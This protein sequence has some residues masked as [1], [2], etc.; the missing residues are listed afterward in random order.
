MS[1]ILKYISSL[2]L[3]FVAVY[4]VQAQK[5]KTETKTKIVADTIK[6]PLFNG[7]TVQGDLIS[8]VSSL[9]SKGETYSYEGA[10]QADF[11]HKYFPVL[12]FG[13]A[14]ADKLTSYNT[15]F[16]ANA[17]FGRLGLDFNMISQKKDKKPT[18]NL[19]LVGFRLGMSKFNYNITNVSITDDYW[20]GSQAVPYNN[21]S[22]TKVWYELVAGIR[23]EVIKD[24]FMGWTV[25]SKSLISKDADGNVTPWY[26]P[27]FGTNNGN[28]NTAINY[29]IGY[30]F[31]LPFKRKSAVKAKKPNTEI[32][33]DTKPD[34]K[35]RNNNQQIK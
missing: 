31:Q 3:C 26:I 35:P 25:R 19:F 14:G 21:I 7:F 33:P 22:T 15:G 16:K 29:T 5:T 34:T 23:V 8:A 28:A 20:G 30:K 18:N 13:Y 32:K 17:L 1:K 11:K 10:L 2:V 24:I 4:S 12:E 6:T 9:T 27:G